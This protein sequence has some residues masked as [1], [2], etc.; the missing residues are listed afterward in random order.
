MWRSWYVPTAVPG[1]IRVTYQLDRTSEGLFDMP[2]IVPIDHNLSCIYCQTGKMLIFLF[3]ADFIAD[4]LVS[5]V[6]WSPTARLPL[7]LRRL[8]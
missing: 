4:P 3:P 6:R 5:Y 1:V 8:L 2:Q 7:E